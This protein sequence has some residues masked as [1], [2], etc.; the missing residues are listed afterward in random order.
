[1]IECQAGIMTTHAIR[2]VCWVEQHIHTGWT[3]AVQH[4]HK[5]SNGHDW[6]V[7]RRSL[8]QDGSDPE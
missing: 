4:D 3:A 5:I 6:L 1:M 2:H 7:S 8:L